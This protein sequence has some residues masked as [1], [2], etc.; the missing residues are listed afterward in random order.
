MTN[1]KKSLLICEVDKSGKVSE[2]L[3]RAV[4]ANQP[5]PVDVDARRMKRTRKEA[6]DAMEVLPGESAVED[7]SLQ[8]VRTLNNGNSEVLDDEGLLNDDHTANIP[9]WRRT[10]CHCA[11][12]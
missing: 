1:V 7:G 11:I 4:I 5:H 8:R 2:V 3:V 6:P 12:A 9:S 10:L